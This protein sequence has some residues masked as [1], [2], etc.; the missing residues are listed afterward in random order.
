MCRLILLSKYNY[1]YTKYVYTQLFFLRIF[2]AR[3]NL[4]LSA[5]F[6]PKGRQETLCFLFVLLHSSSFL[7]E[8]S[9]FSRIFYHPR[10]QQQFPR[11]ELVASSP[12]F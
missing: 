1:I 5:L 11:N 2:V 12:R 10:L 8:L 9:T 4:F 6:F 3:E 7:R